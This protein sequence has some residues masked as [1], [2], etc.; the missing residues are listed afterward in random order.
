MGRRMNR[1]G[2]LKFGAAAAAGALAFATTYLATHDESQTLAV[3]RLTI[4]IRGLPAALTGFRLVQI[5]DIHLYPFTRLD[6][7]RR[8]VAAANDLQPDLTVLTGDF[9]WRDVAAIFDLAPVLG[10]LNARHGVYAIRGNHEL[11]T[12]AAVVEQGLQEVRIPLLNN[13]GVPVGEGQ[14]LFFLAGLDDGWSGQ[15][16]LTTALASRPGQAPVILLMHEPDLADRYAA[17]GRIA[18]Q[19]SGHSHGGQIRFP[20]L[21]PLILPYLARK[22]DMGLY[23]I[24][25]MWL[26]TN[27][28]LGV[29]NEPVRYNCPPEVTEI[30][31]VRA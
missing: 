13:A 29:T 28:G 5:S 24:G 3:E 22:Y 8:A 27:R 4:P 2:F 23:R 7:V 6:L 26:Y 14:D 20:R 12:D 21:G 1:R 25:E 18:L 15:P 17:D 31:L 11:W 9:V 16:D 10:S 30:T 19:L